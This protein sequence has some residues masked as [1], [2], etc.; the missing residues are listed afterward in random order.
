M[1][2]PW[3][4]L[5]GFVLLASGLALLVT[6]VVAPDAEPLRDYGGGLILSSVGMLGG[7]GINAVQ[8]AVVT[9]GETITVPPPK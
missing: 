4:L 8:R 6:S 5:V 1:P 3:S 7:Q 9:P 2:F